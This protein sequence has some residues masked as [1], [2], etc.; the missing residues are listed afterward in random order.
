MR[1]GYTVVREAVSKNPEIMAETALR[2]VDYLSEV[3][4][5]PR[6]SLIIVNTPRWD[7]NNSK[8]YQ[9]VV[10]AKSSKAHGYDSGI[11][12][13]NGEGDAKGIQRPQLHC[14]LVRHCGFLFV[15]FSSTGSLKLI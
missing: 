2:C 12:P 5:S 10:Y 7:T 1:V 14:Q 6:P 4:I 3:K 11:R 13:E 9:I 15:L 8:P